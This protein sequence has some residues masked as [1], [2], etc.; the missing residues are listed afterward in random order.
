ML[1]GKP[2]FGNVTEDRNMLEILRL[3]GPD[4]V[5]VVDGVYF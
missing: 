4:K 5:T 2:L 3:V 1:A